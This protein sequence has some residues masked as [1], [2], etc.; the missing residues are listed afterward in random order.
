MPVTAEVTTWVVD[1]GSPKSEATW[2][3]IGPTA[4]GAEAVDGVQ[5]GDLLAQGA[6]EAER[7]TE[8]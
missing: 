2:M 6:D 5:L 3:M 7:L 1:T 4:L 8:R